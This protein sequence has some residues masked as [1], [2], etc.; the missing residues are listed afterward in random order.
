MQVF[1]IT[2]I[3]GVTE[4]I[5]AY[6]QQ[7]MA[8]G[9]KI[10][11]IDPYQGEKQ[12]FSNEQIAYQHFK[13]ECGFEGYVKKISAALT[14]TSREKIILGFSV[15]AAA[16]YKA[17]DKLP[18]AST[19]EMT[20]RQFIGFYPGQ[21]RHQLEI[22][23][24][25]P[26]TLIFPHS[27]QHFELDKV[28]ASLTGKANVCCI[29]TPFD[30]GFMNPLSVN[31]QQTAANYYFDQLSHE[32]MQLPPPALQRLLLPEQIKQTLSHLNH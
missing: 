18:A 23:P 15:G 17:I 21:I 32:N 16:A 5:F 25:R 6:K 29:K 9:C 26:V 11:V 1:I 8:S 19:Q 2:D 28:I 31:Y 14:K 22:T 24:R 20:I 3:F 12:D 13:Q 7:L 10:Q 30:H 4:Q 27:E